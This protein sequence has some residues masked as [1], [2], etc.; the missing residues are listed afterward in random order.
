M[1]AGTVQPENTITRQRLGRFVS[2]ATDMNA[3][4]EELLEAVFSMRWSKDF[5]CPVFEHVYQTQCLGV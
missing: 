3:K 2:T 5:M 1:M 4:I